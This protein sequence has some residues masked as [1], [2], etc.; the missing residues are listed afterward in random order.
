[1]SVVLLGLL[2]KAP[3]ELQYCYAGY[4]L[5]LMYVIRLLNCLLLLCVILFPACGS[6]KNQP[7]PPLTTRYKTDKSVK[8]ISFDAKIGQLIMVGFYGRY[9]TDFGVK[10]L[11]SHIRYGRIGGVILHGHNIEKPSQLGNLTKLLISASPDLLIAVDQEGG[12]VQRLTPLKGFIG[13]PSPIKM[14]GYSLD[15]VTRIYETQAKQLARYGINVNFAPVVDLNSVDPKKSSPAI[16]QYGRSFGSDAQKVKSLATI[17][18]KAHHKFGIK[19]VLKHFPG[20]GLLQ[21]DTHLGLY[22]ISPLPKGR[23]AQELGVFKVLI[24]EGLAD[25]VMTAHLFDGKFDKKYPATFSHN[26]ITLKLRKKYGFRGIVITDD[27]S[28]ASIRSN[29][30]LKQTVILAL[31]AGVDIL[32]FS[33]NPSLTK[34]TKG[35]VPHHNLPFAIRS[36]VKS[37]IHH[38][39]LSRNT[40]IESWRRQ[41]IFMQKKS[42]L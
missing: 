31:G 11:L 19:T 13:A 40:I 1:L 2:K 39:Q 6:V 36:I 26:I 10:N 27:L 3:I 38:N 14:A 25:M 18:I 28:M 8:R 37:A 21:G 29:Y 35:F 16:G 30:S 23:R 9:S 33:H 32:L 7:R 42:D 41:R 17:M 20:H 4:G 12:N 22:E 34:T 24:K 5:L 15:K